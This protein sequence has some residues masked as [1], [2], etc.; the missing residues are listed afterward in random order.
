MAAFHG[1]TYR[2]DRWWTGDIPI[3][4]HNLKAIHG[5]YTYVQ[6]W[7]LLTTTTTTTTTTNIYAMKIGLVIRNA[8]RYTRT[9]AR[10]CAR[11]CMHACTRT[12][13]QYLWSSVVVRF[14]NFNSLFML[15][16]LIRLI[17]FRCG[18]WMSQSIVIFLV[19]LLRVLNHLINLTIAG[20]QTILHSADCSSRPAMMHWPVKG[21]LFMLQDQHLFWGDKEHLFLCVQ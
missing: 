8:C 14:H 9:H 12:C 3:T 20:L 5:V 21:I 4:A 19:K 18:W 17:S 7:W 15:C 10:T 16:H 6:P 11:T 13:T 2:V 1:N